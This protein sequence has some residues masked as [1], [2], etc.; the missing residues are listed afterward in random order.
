MLVGLL[1]LHTQ[2]FG[3]TGKHNSVPIMFSWFATSS[4]G[5]TDSYSEHVEDGMLK[6]RVVKDFYNRLGFV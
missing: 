2:E 1:V 6:V 5:K 4:G 3:F